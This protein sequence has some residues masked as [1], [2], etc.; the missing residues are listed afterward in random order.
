MLTNLSGLVIY[1][2]WNLWH[3]SGNRSVDLASNACSAV[4][5]NLFSANVYPSLFLPVFQQSDFLTSFKYR[6]P[7]MSDGRSFLLQILTSSS[8]TISRKVMV[9]CSM[10][11]YFHQYDGPIRVWFLNQPFSLIFKKNTF[12]VDREICSRWKRKKEPFG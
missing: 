12:L 5:V 10:A 7:Q 8:R 6:L 9:I 2:V 4:K 11:D 3:T 1:L